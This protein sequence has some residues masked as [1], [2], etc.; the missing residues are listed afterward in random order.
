[1]EGLGGKE[2]IE[3]VTN[4]ATRL[5]TT[6]YDT[7]KVLDDSYF[8]EN[9]ALGM[10]RKKNNIQVIVGPSVPQVRDEVDKLL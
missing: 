7:E 6:V 3:S 8:Q 2:N 10:V 1:M 4:C 5:R 9:G